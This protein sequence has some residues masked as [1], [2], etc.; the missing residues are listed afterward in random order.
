MTKTSRNTN[1]E[2]LRV[3]FMFVILFHHFFSHGL[4][5]GKIGGDELPINIQ[6][7]IYASFHLVTHFGVV[8]FMFISSYYGITLKTNK[9]IRLWTQLLFYS[10]FITLGYSLLTNSFS[11]IN[12]LYA[13]FP[14]RIWWFCKFYFII[15][16][17]SPI[18]N[19][20]VAS[21]NKK[22]FTFIIISLGIIILFSRFILKESSFNL[23]LLLY[24][25]ILG[26]YLK[27][28]P[29]KWFESHCIPVFVFTTLILFFLPLTLLKF[30]QVSLLSYFWSNNNILVFIQA[31][32]CFYMFLNI[33]PIFKS[34]INI[35][36]SVLAVYL[37]TD[38]PIIR[39]VI[40]NNTYGIPAAY[41]TTDSLL[42]VTLL[43]IIIF[44]I[45]IIIDRA[46]EFVM[47]PINTYLGYL[48]LL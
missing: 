24:V 7:S 38:H 44:C 34:R 3:F 15:M 26:R 20:G 37:I 23:E 22:T 21:I 43:L 2:I 42:I 6:N 18:I 32:S 41:K 1:I 17:L 27:E 46:R 40:W 25:Y 5:I 47:R 8:G 14:L 33:K 29:I 19:E 12:L 16:I 13:V 28:Y 4:N 31:I 48:E 36:S 45:C 39:S 35:A 9:V 30:R 10:F 11:A